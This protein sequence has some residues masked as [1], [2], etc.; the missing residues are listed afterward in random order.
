GGWGQEWR[1]PGKCGR[2]CSGCEGARR[3]EGQSG[4]YFRPLAESYWPD[5]FRQQV[6]GI[7]FL[8][9]SKHA[10]LEIAEPGS[11]FGPGGSGGRYRD[12]A[13]AVGNFRRTPQRD[14]RL[15][16]G[17]NTGGPAAESRGRLESFQGPCR[18]G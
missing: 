5:R 14:R 17:R 3:S 7:Q 10:I 8:L 4:Q 2:G 9:C 12:G 18:A 16:L 13:K 11:F 6:I 15:R 1:A